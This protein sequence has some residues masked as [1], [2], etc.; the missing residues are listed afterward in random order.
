MPIFNFASKKA[1]AAD[2]LSSYI[3][4]LSPVIVKLPGCTK[5]LGSGITDLFSSVKSLFSGKAG[6]KVTSKAESKLSVDTIGTTDVD[7]N[8]KLDT[9]QQTTSDTQKAVSNQDKN[10][11]CLNAIGKSI[12]KVLVNRIT[13]STIDWI[14]TGYAGDPLYVQNPGALFEGIAKDEFLGVADEIN[15][16][17]KYPFGK[18]FLQT[19]K[20]VFA[21][22]FANN[23]QY[24]LSQHI[25]DENPGL[26]YSA[27][28][29]SKDFSQGGW[30]AWNAMTQSSANNPLGFTLLASNELA[31]R[32]ED[33]TQLTE[34]SLQQ[35]GGFLAVDKCTDPKGMTKQE[36]QAARVSNASSPTGPYQPVC[37]NWE[38]VTPG[39]L[40][41]D[42]LTSAVDK[43][44]SSIL[45][46]QTLNDAMAA[47]LDAVL[48]KFSSSL[49]SE[50]GLAGV[51][52][53]NDYE[54][55]SSVSG[56]GS[57]QIDGDFSNAQINESN[58]LQQHPDFNIRTDL[59]QALIDEQ[60]IYQ[61]KI[62]EQNDDI[63][64][65]GPIT[66]DN[67]LGKY[68]LIPTIYQLDYCI[69]G[70]HPGW[71]DEA[72]MTLEDI[73]TKEGSLNFSDM[74]ESG[75]YQLLDSLSL[76]GLSTV[77]N[78]V[79]S[80]AFKCGSD[81]GKQ[82]ANTY[83]N[84]FNQLTTGGDSTWIDTKESKN[85]SFCS[86][87]GFNMATNRVQ[88][89]YE[90]VINKFYDLSHLPSTA[91]EAKTYFGRINDYM[92]TMAN[93]QKTIDTLTGVITRLNDLKS[94]IDA[95][96]EELAADTI[97][98]DEYENGNTDKKIDGII[99]WKNAFARISAS[100]YSGDDIA[101]I[102]NAT[103]KIVDTKDYV[104]NN[105]LKGATGCEQEVSKN[106]PRAFNWQIY[107]SVRPNYPKPHLYD[108]PGRLSIDGTPAST[109][110]P[111]PGDKTFTPAT[112][113]DNNTCP[114][115]TTDCFNIS[116]YVDTKSP[117][118]AGSGWYWE[119]ALG[120][121]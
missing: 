101:S 52:T 20:N 78:L 30:G 45:D 47:I 21:S 90:R 120:I 98:Q 118:Y 61:S 64:S 31:K 41:A 119:N 72:Q 38:I 37:N 108:Y 84:E 51:N 117:H 104:Y 17:T 103:K 77:V 16:P 87:E 36:D 27:E 2:S 7:A 57:F 34:G 13:D 113:F 88:T 3:T 73:Q 54:I 74:T 75:W 96:N 70:P 99:P 58:W 24:T 81:S 49:Q 92:Q 14:N 82:A 71:Q 6:S 80:Y 97:T 121:W 100:L 5:A 112:V 109:T 95:L 93:N 85:G 4:S 23:S 50:N 91:P 28:G 55:N 106:N 29:F 35:S 15:D 33:K 116:G 76:S 22:K 26:G 83:M 69:P 59:N 111:T 46:V 32:I 89:E 60:R 12:A 79:N 43:K 53:G 63:M 62:Q 67:E 8:T 40:I 39:K 114:S 105:L 94:K 10:E 56:L 66:G 65:N 48:A 115:W 44:D 68:G 1:Q 86:V 25:Q 18:A 110:P 107:S 11:N 9:I 42:Q 102:D 19:E